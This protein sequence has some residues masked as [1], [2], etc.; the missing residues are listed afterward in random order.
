LD[1]VALQIILLRGG[2]RMQKLVFFLVMVLALSF[3]A[4]APVKKE[5]GPRIKCPACG[6]EFEAPK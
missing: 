4:C 6:Y 1:W 3:T 2:E 5:E